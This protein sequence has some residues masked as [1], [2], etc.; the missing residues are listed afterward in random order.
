MEQLVLD[1]LDR[2]EG[3][4]REDINELKKTLDQINKT[5]Y[6]GNGSKSLVSRVDLVEDDVNGLKETKKE[7]LRHIYGIT[8]GMLTTIGS[9]VAWLVNSGYIKFVGVAK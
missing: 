9:I 5:V 3:N 2:L 8:G 1:R 7:L 6:I 4:L